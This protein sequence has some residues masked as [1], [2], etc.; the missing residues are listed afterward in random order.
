MHHITRV[1][2]LQLKGKGIRETVR[3]TGISR[4][5]IRE[6]LKHINASG[7]SCIY[8]KLDKYFIPL[9]KPV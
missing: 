2:E 9:E 1:I 3:L 7:L 8:L 5:T 6:Y 4:N